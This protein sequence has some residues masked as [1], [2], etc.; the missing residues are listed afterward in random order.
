MVG[1][2]LLYLK[3]WIQNEVENWQPKFTEHVWG[4]QVPEVVL[5]QLNNEL[6]IYALRSYKNNRLIVSVLQGDKLFDGY[7]GG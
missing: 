4:K 6:R 2:I 1:F 5:Y 7:K 3:Q